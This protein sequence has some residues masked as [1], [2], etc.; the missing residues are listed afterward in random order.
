MATRLSNIELDEVSLVD[1]PANEG[2]KILLFKRKDAVEQTAFEKRVED[3][4]KRDDCSGTIA[5][6][7]ARREY[8][9]D[10]EAYQRDG[11]VTSQPVTKEVVK[12]DAVLEWERLVATIASQEGISR[13]AAMRRARQQNPDLFER[14]RLVSGIE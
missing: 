5:L 1:K 12:Q 14:M 11:A 8:S 9:K 10:F 4:R 13:T 6:Q 3:M 7:R 2:A